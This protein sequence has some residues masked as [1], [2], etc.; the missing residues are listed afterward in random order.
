M[1]RLLNF[2]I[3]MFYL[4]AVVTSKDLKRTGDIWVC[5][6]SDHVCTRFFFVFDNSQ[7]YQ[8]EVVDTRVPKY[9]K[10]IDHAVAHLKRFRKIA[11]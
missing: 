6:N 11:K 1:K 8:N 7:G 4:C 3:I 10:Q 9:K 2:K 5:P